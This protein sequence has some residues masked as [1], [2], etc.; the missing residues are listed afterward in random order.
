MAIVYLISTTAAVA[1][2]IPL[3]SS[4]GLVGGAVALL[5]IDVAMSAYVLPAALRIV[6][7]SPGRFLRVV[8]DLRGAVRSARAFGSARLQ[9]RRAAIASRQDKVAP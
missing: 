9:A 1:L 4:F 6:D 5:A 3:A 8:L 2:A 7:D